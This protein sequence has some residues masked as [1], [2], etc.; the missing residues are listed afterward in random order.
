MSRYEAIVLEKRF[1]RHYT[2]TPI[3]T[4]EL[5]ILAVSAQFLAETEGRK[6]RFPKIIKHLRTAKTYCVPLLTHR[7]CQFQHLRAIG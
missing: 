4:R 6:M 7:V 2:D 5:Q 3:F 1:E